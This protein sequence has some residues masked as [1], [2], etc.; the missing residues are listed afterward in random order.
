V[1]LDHFERVAMTHKRHDATAARVEV[2]S[3]V[4]LFVARL[5]QELAAEV[6]FVDRHTPVRHRVGQAQD[7]D[8]REEDGLECHR[9]VRQAIER[10][11]ITLNVSRVSRQAVS[12]RDRVIPCYFFLPELSP[13]FPRRPAPRRFTEGPPLSDV[14]VTYEQGWGWSI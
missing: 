12:A 14:A 2:L 13:P 11:T 10:Y 5:Q 7:R 1:F 8:E 9:F 4:G 3:A 6:G